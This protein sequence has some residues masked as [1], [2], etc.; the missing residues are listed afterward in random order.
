L[1]QY[2]SVLVSNVARAPARFAAASVVVRSGGQDSAPMSVQDATSLSAAL[3]TVPGVT[4]S[5]SDYTFYAQP[6]G[7]DI[8]EGYGWSGATLAR[9]PLVAG[10]PPTTDSEVNVGSDLGIDPGS[11]VTIFTSAG[12]SQYTAT[13]VVEGSGLYFADGF[14][15]RSTTGVRAI[16]LVLAPDAD[17]DQVTAAATALVGDRTRVLVGDERATLESETDA[18]RRNGGAILLGTMASISI[19]VSVFVVASTFALSVAQRRREIGLLRAVG[20]TPR[21]VRRMM[22]SEALM[23]GL[24]AAACG[25]VLALPLT[26]VL[27]DLLESARLVASGFTPHGHRVAIGRRGRRWPPRSDAG[28][29]VRLAAGGPGAAAGS[30]ARGDPRHTTDDCQPLDI[31]RP[32]HLRWYRPKLRHRLIRAGGRAQRSRLRGH[33]THHR[34]HPARAGAHPAHRPRR[35]LAV[36]PLPRGAGQSSSGRTH[37]SPCGAPRPPPHPCCS[38]WAL[39]ALFTA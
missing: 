16:G 32:L 7:T 31:R 29:L 21:Q 15:R 35:G 27:G 22:L 10:T 33:G 12:P 26:P 6:A 20:A 24:V 37:W 34:P 11:T 3:S 39:A 30:A 17:L 18:G 13:G 25:T 23:I 9:R 36:G 2:P 1:R 4:Q 28:S 19:F 5:I 38:P 8:T 14:A